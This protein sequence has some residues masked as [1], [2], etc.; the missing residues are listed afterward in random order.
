LATL[1]LVSLDDLFFLDFLAGARI[2]RPEHDPSCR[3][4]SFRLILDVIR[5]EPRKR[6]VGG[7]LSSVLIRQIVRFV[8]RS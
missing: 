8:A 2:V 6:S 3:A 7:I 4:N 5:S 1:I